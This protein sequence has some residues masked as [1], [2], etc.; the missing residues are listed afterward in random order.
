MHRV[1]RLDAVE[2]AANTYRSRG[3]TGVYFIVE[4][5]L[6]GRSYTVKYYGTPSKVEENHVLPK[7]RTLRAEL[8][9]TQ[10]QISKALG[11][12]FKTYKAYERNKI[13]QVHKY[14]ALYNKMLNLKKQKELKETS[15]PFGRI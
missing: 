1:M 2:Q 8:G 15:L 10:V 3:W 14:E 13:T 6:K 4:R 5:A 9:L 12:K 7:I 11:M